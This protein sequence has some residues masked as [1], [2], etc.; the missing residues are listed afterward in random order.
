VRTH[1]VGGALLAFALAP[2]GA[3]A[4]AHQGLE[5]KY[6]RDGEEYATVVRQIYRGAV[7]AVVRRRDSLPKGTP[8]TVVLDVDETTLDNSTYQ[9]ERLAY[10]LPFE[11]ASW[12]AW[13]ARREAGLVPG[14]LAFLT[15]VR[16]AGGRVAFI[17]NRDEV[18]RADTRANL[19][20]V[21]AYRD[22]DL[23]CLEDGQDY[24]KP[25]RRRELASGEGR[26]AWDGVRPVVLAFVGDQL[27]DFPSSQE[28][29]PDAG[30]DEAFGIRFFLLPNPMY[31]RWDRAVTRL[32]GPDR[33]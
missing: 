11:S 13:V 28:P 8:W 24:T 31:G 32:R 12:N 22:G 5:I 26:C 14:V 9:L 33:R 18:T 4:Q 29:F 21:G 25:V 23:L 16:A 6:V 15:A 20:H 10:D 7:R 3:A 2:A 17:S 30:G 1:W 27:S 19:E